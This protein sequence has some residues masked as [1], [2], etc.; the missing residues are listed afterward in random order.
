VPV[1]SVKE[2]PPPECEGGAP[3]AEG[4]VVARGRL[5]A[6]P[7]VRDKK[8]EEAFVIRRRDCLWEFESE[9]KWSL[10]EA[11]V[12]A[13]YDEDLTP[14][15]VHLTMDLPDRGEDKRLYELRNDPVT[16]THE[17]PSGKERYRRLRGPRPQAL[18]GPGRGLLSMWIRRVDLEVGGKSAL[19]ILDF[20]QHHARID[21]RVVLRRDP[22]HDVEWR[23]EPVPV[24]T[25]FGREPVFANDDGVVIGDLAGLRPPKK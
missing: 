25:V 1:E 2:Q 10:G 24:Y 17:L 18:V 16:L 19:P 23:S 9:Q 3:P 6:G 21:E 15:Q 12:R 13:I 14:L 20:R 11:K 5:V 4:T 8:R 7:G 22:N